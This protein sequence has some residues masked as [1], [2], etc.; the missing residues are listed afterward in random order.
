MKILKLCEVKTP[1]RS[2]KNA[3]IDFFV[4]SNFEEVNL[5]PNEDILIKSGLKVRLPKDHCLI[6]FNKSGIATKHKLQVGACVVDENY[7]GELHLHVTN[8]GTIK[9][10]IKP[11]MKIMQFILIKPFY[12]H[13]E[14]VSS[15]EELTANM[16]IDER[17]SNGFGSTGE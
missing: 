9:R 14:E 3:G 10:A 16:N 12:D 13:I 7:T 1:E 5:Y 4:P 6:A 8:V 11:D 2:G 17:G 15:F